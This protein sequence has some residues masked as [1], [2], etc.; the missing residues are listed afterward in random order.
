MIVCDDVCDDCATDCYLKKQL[1]AVRWKA[2][3]FIIRRI[4][5]EQAEFYKTNHSVIN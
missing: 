3:Y 2:Y 4:G 5:M 1:L